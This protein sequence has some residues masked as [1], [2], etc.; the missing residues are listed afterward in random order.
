[1]ETKIH[2]VEFKVSSLHKKL[3]FSS[4]VSELWTRDY[5]GLYFWRLSK[6]YDAAMPKRGREEELDRSTMELERSSQT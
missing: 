5:L 1:M 2:L 4:L 6:L 3:A